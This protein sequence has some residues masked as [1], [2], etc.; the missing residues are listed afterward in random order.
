[1][2]SSFII[3]TLPSVSQHHLCDMA[4]Q[5]V[6]CIEIRKSM[7]KGKKEQKKKKEKCD[8]RYLKR[9]HEKIS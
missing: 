9:R 5:S 7:E 8:D 2:S 6:I 1:M 3:N 4:V